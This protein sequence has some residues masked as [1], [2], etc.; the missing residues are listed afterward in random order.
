MKI[1]YLAT[2]GESGAPL[3]IEREVDMLS[4][5]FGGTV[6]E[7]EALPWTRAENLVRDLSARH[8]DVLH[9]TAHGEGEG[10]QVMNEQGA[11]V[12]M[13]AEHILSF[14]PRHRGPRLIYLNACDSVPVAEQLAKHVPFAIGS[15]LPIGNDISIH[16]ALSFYVA[17][18]MI[19]GIESPLDLLSQ[20]LKKP[21]KN[22]KDQLPA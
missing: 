19:A 9:I 14:L 2:R 4:R 1:L 16:G 17:T 7:F 11:A 5:M 13:S 6:V 8:F 10:L 15:T 12:M 3:T 20:P 22:R 18:G 21:K